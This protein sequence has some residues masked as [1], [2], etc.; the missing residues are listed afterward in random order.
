M[1]AQSKN[2][3]VVRIVRLA[4]VGSAAAVPIIASISI[5]NYGAYQ[6]SVFTKAHTSTGRNGQA[7]LR[8]SLPTPGGEIHGFVAASFGGPWALRKRVP[9]AQVFVQTAAGQIAQQ[10]LTQTTSQGCFRVLAPGVY[11]VCAS[12]SGFA[13]ACVFYSVINYSVILLETITLKPLDTAIRGWC[14]ADFD[15]KK[16]GRRWRPP[17]EFDHLERLG[18]R[19]FVKEPL[20]VKSQRA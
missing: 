15:G 9:Q 17:G 3:K 13:K 16:P 18:F 1:P 4:S 6:R 8:Q 19:Q 2:E 20:S 11:N 14:W 10:S 12:L 7:L 5:K